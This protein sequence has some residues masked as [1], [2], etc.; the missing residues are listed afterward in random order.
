MASTLRVG[1][2]L[3]NPGQEF[4]FTADS[5]ISEMDVLGD[6]VHF[7][8]IAVSGTVVGTSESVS[9]KAEIRANVESLCAR[10]REKVSS[11][12]VAEMD[13]EFVREP[14]SENP[15]LYAFEGTTVDLS[16]AISDA[17]ILA[18]PFRFLCKEDCKGLCPKCGA[19]LNTGSC[20]CPKDEED[21]SNPFAALRMIVDHNE[22]V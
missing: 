22:E 12:I 11:P 9:V 1:D 20:S 6:P 10:C 7:E 13:A 3:K 19:N 14:D 2:A 5:E 16:Q 17:L 4:P 18:L 8:N 21:D 15:D